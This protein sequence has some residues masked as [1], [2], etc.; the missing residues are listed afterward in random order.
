MRVFRAFFVFSG[1]CLGLAAC[2][3]RDTAPRYE[4]ACF[5]E[6]NVLEREKRGDAQAAGRDL[7]SCLNWK[8]EEE[9]ARTGQPVRQVVTFNGQPTAGGTRAPAAP[10]SKTTQ[11]ASGGA[12]PVIDTTGGWVAPAAAPI[13][14]SPQITD[15][16]KQ[17]RKTMTGGTGY[18]CS[19]N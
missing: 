13:R 8:Y 14:T 3:Q 7:V 9:A 19:A 1:L 10:V 17:C 15:P 18:G 4:A 5:A 6:T 12:I 16:E 11:A 2:A